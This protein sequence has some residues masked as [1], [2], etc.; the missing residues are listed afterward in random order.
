MWRM[1]WIHQ[2]RGVCIIVLC[3]G[4]HVINNNYWP[5]A[6]YSYKYYIVEIQISTYDSKS[7]NNLDRLREEYIS[8]PSK[9]VP[10]VVCLNTST[11]TTQKSVSQHSVIVPAWTIP[12]NNQSCTSTILECSH[13]SWRGLVAVG[14]CSS[15]LRALTIAAQAKT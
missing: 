9:L 1:W 2:G 14:G 6:W 10:Q 15:M 12:T 3:Y 8:Y 5:K 4:I 13:I 11:C 7:I